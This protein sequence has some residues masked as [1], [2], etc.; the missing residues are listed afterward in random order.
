M[1]DYLESRCCYSDRFTNTTHEATDA[2]T[3]RQGWEGAWPESNATG[4]NHIRLSD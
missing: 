1:K 4:R 2:D 3:K